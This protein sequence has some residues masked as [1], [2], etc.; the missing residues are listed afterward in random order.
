MHDVC[1]VALWQRTATLHRC[2]TAEAMIV[3]GAHGEYERNMPYVDRI[4]KV[5]W[6]GASLLSGATLA[7]IPVVEGGC[8]GLSALPRTL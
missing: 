2:L 5:V 6:V 3:D 7:G 4:F 1:V 8:M